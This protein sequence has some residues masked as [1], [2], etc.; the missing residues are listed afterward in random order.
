LRASQFSLQSWGFGLGRSFEHLYDRG[1]SQG[2]IFTSPVSSPRPSL[3]D[4]AARAMD[5]ELV[6]VERL[7]AAVQAS[8]LRQAVACQQRFTACGAREL[9]VVHLALSWQLSEARVGVLL[10][11][12]RYLLTVLPRVLAAL[13]DGVV[14]PEMVEVLIE[15]CDVLEPDVAVADQVL[16]AVAAGR[17]PDASAVRVRARRASVRLAPGS[18]RHGRSAPQRTGM[19]AGGPS[20]TGPARWS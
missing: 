8:R 15:V 12:G 19:C 9:A 10:H 1:M 11:Q 3:D 18:A 6:E 17:C 13:T 7:R 5:A 2:P 14:G 20:R 4:D 16:T